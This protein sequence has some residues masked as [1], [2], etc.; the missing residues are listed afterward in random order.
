MVGN[1]VVGDVI[2]FVVGMPMVVPGTV[3]GTVIGGLRP[4]LVVWVALNG[5]LAPLS[6]GALPGV[7]SGG[8]P[9]PV[10]GWKTVAVQ[11]VNP[12][13][14][15]VPLGVVEQ[16][17]SGIG[18][19]PPGLISVAPSGMP[20]VAGVEAGVE[21]AP[22]ASSGDV[23][24]IAGGVPRLCASTA[25]ESVSIAANVGRI[26]RMGISRSSSAR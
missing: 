21:V 5:M 9:P 8:T 11:P 7:G 2:V 25:P 10:G 12:P 13:P 18:L 17:V 16:E 22:G 3:L 1:V 19:K 4:A 24:R 6:V 20:D 15:K 26:R 23:A 14:S